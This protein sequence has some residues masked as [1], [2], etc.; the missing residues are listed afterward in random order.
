MST[1]IREEDLS[2]YFGVREKALK[3]LEEYKKLFRVD[4]WRIAIDD[5]YTINLYSEI[6][7]DE[8]DLRE[9]LTCCNEN[10]TFQIVK[11]EFM[12]YIVRARF[13]LKL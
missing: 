6:P 12:K 2:K 1:K 10:Y 11:T 9:M 4:T 13:H 7:L 3:K 8:T 5:C